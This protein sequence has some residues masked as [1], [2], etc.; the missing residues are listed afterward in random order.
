MNSY[1]LSGPK[2]INVLYAL[3]DIA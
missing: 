2:S 3:F 1:N